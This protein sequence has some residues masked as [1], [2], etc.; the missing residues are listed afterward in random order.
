MTH[1]VEL[2]ITFADV[3]DLH[4]RL[5]ELRA[6][7]PVARVLHDGE[8]AWIL[9]RYDSVRRALLDQSTFPLEAAYS[10]STDRA[11]GRSLMSMDGPEHTRSRSVVSPPF[12][13]S[14]VARYA[15]TIIT[16]TCQELLG[17]LEGSKEFDLRAEYTRPIPLLVITRL[18]G[19]P[20]HDYEIMEGW[21][22]DLFKFSREPETALRARAEFTT[23]LEAA[24]ERRRSSPHDDLIATLL[25]AAD[26]GSAFSTDEIHSFVRLLFPA[27]ADS[28]ANGLGNA[29][30][31]VLTQ[32]PDELDRLAVDDDRASAAVEE[33]LRWEGPIPHIPRK[34]PH[35]CTW[36]GVHIPPG[37]DVIFS[38]ASANRDPAVFTNPDRFNLDRQG[39]DIITFGLGHHFCLGAQLARQEMRIALQTLLRRVRHIELA[40][41][42]AG[43]PIGAIMRG[44]AHLPVRVAW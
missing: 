37:G 1:A 43:A 36:D 22:N 17:R 30:Y 10:V 18:L 3:T 33:S 31:A 9:L 38:Y 35:G 4:G 21:A 41:H 6:Q 23:Y 39:G 20:P 15:E 44:P 5:A 2:D 40:D 28:T 14:A 32:C 16:P 13:K 25:G 11:I 8:P 24:L 27:G 12:R 7:G 42:A 26:G 29:V 34:A 19:L